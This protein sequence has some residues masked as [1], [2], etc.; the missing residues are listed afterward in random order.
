MRERQRDCEKERNSTPPETQDKTSLHVS[1]VSSTP[2]HSATPPSGC[3]L[4]EISI[5]PHLSLDSFPFSEYTRKMLW[6]LRHF[7]P[8]A[9]VYLKGNE[10]DFS[11]VFA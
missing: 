1:P 4:K 7:R 10:A 11:G 2:P 8:P 9:P 3:T 5:K 6:P